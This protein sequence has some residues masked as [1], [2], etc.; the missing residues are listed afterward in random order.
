MKKNKIAN[1]INKWD[2]ANMTQN[3]L[4][5]F[6]W[7]W[8]L[9]MIINEHHTATSLIKRRKWMEGDRAS[10]KWKIILDLREWKYM[11]WCWTRYRSSGVITFL[12]HFIRARRSICTWK[13][14]WKN[15]NIN[16]I[17]GTFVAWAWTYM[18]IRA[19]CAV[20][21]MTINSSLC[22]SSVETCWNIQIK[23]MH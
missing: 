15:K 16:V 9:L 21:L 13:S 19:L 8:F 18:R 14:V 10:V 5:Y 1:G 6:M 23:Q 4:Y 17:H 2:N 7:H 11:I 22:T 12:S 20:W 3:Y